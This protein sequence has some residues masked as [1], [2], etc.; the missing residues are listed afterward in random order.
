MDNLANEKIDYNDKKYA[1]VLQLISSET[2]QYDIKEFYSLAKAGKYEVID[3]IIQKPKK[4]HPKLFF[5]RGKVEEI[6]NKIPSYFNK[7]NKSSFLTKIEKRHEEDLVVL[8]NNR[9]KPSQ[10]L[11]ISN[12]LKT[13]VIDR[14]FLILEIFERKAKTK[15][16]KLQIK[17]ARLNLETSQ[18]QK[19]LSEKLKTERQGRD[20]HGKGYNAVYAYKTAYRKERRAIIEKL[21]KIRQNRAI[22]RKNRQN[23]FKIA[24]VGYTNAGKTTFLNTI[25]NISLETEDSAF[26]TAV[27]IAK[28]VQI[29]KESIIF[30]DTVGFV[31]DIPNEIIDAFLST[32]EET[33]FSNLILL[34]IDISENIDKIKQKIR[35]TFQIIYRIGA[36]SIPI[37][38]AFNKIDKV[39]NKE[40]ILKKNQVLTIVPKNSIVFFLSAINK[41]SALNLVKLL[42]MIKNNKLIV[43]DIEKD[44]IQILN[45]KQFLINK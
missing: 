11:A 29:N 3:T 18:K 16:A 38:F 43:E 25:R 15:E 30:I 1:I 24:I 39:D 19:E 41:Q 20:F 14:D 13:K 7:I 45:T 22:Q 26:T 8:V 27:P 17:L 9:L 40:L 4:I 33:V 32:L 44:V 34:L 28:R 12:F 23:E 2:P 6:L 21:T 31:E 10:I 35:T 37:V 36:L 5:G 42:I